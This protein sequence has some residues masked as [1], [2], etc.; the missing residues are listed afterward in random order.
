MEENTQEQAGGKSMNM[1]MVLVAVVVLV[2]LGGGAY[3]YM[4]QKSQ[5]APA[6][7]Q[8]QSMQPTKMQATE[9][10]SMAPTTS[11]TSQSAAMPSGKVVEVT[12]K[13]Q[14]YSFTPNQITVKKGD[15]VKV[16]FMNTGG[17]HDF[18]LDEFNVKTK[19]I[20]D[21]ESDTVQFVAD[22]AGTFEF[23]CGVGQHRQ[24]GMKGNLIVQ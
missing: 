23:Y 16:T 3:Y 20:K 14:N 22:K 18:I 9:A 12:V 4:N 21:G 1:T 10:P 6:R 7:E 11:A 24:M 2:L 15:T 17:F 5:M 19:T 8:N 13:G